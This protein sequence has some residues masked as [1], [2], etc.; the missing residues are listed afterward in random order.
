MA[1]RFTVVFAYCV[2]VVSARASA[3]TSGLRWLPW[4]VGPAT[5]SANSVEVSSLQVDAQT[6]EQWNIKHKLSFKCICSLILTHSFG[7]ALEGYL[8]CLLSHIPKPL[9]SVSTRQLPDVQAPHPTAWARR[10]DEWFL[11]PEG[12]CSTGMRTGDSWWHDTCVFAVS[13]AEL[14]RWERIS[15]LGLKELKVWWLFWPNGAQP[16]GLPLDKPQLQSY[17]TARRRASHLMCPGRVESVDFVYQNSSTRFIIW[18]SL[19]L[20]CLDVWTTS[21]FNAVVL[22]RIRNREGI[23]SA[24]AICLWPNT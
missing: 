15:I 22:K 14:Q 1:T 20:L 2:S 18:M 8:E 4:W 16:P 6:A 10:A 3:G 5:K 12:L 24:C 21:T 9:P 11:R 7:Q 13:C 17:L 23:G 19:M